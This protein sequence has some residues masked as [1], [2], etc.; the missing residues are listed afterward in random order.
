MPGTPLEDMELLARSKSGDVAAFAA[1]VRHYEERVYNLACRLV[2]NS[3][4]A[5]D[6]A[7]DAFLAAYE[8]LGRFRGDAAFYTWLYR[9]VVNKALTYRKAR[10]ARPEFAASAGN[11]S[12]FDSV[13]DETDDPLAA[14]ER[15]EEQAAVQAAIAALPQDFRAVVVLKDIEGFEYEEIADILSIALGT[16]KSRLHRGRLLLREALKPYLGVTP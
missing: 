16:V 5:A 1:L 11:P 8:G 7:Q 15:K 4:D 12:P 2:G 13:G 14:A 10:A 9:I 3:S 6:I